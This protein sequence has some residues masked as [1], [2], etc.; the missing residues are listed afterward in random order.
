MAAWIYVIIYQARLNEKGKEIRGV[1]T[2]EKGEEW[3]DSI[4][5][6]D[7]LI[8]HIWKIDDKHSGKWGWLF[9]R[10]SLMYGIE[11]LMGCVEGEGDFI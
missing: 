2:T 1:G 10:V 8:G 3:V 4:F 6:F 7:Q 11:S 9:V 5:R